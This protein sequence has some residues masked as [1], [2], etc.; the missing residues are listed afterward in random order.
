VNEE[1]SVRESDVA[2]FNTDAV[3]AVD[4]DL[5]QY[6]KKRA[7]TAPSRRFRICLHQSA[8]E[9]V[10]EMIVVHCRENYSRPHR[11]AAATSCLIIEGDLTVV[12]FDDDGRE[13][14]RIELGT[15][16][17]GKPFTLRLGPDIWHMPV[18]RS[19]QLV[20]YETLEG[21]FERER[22]NVWAPWS[23]NEDDAE[24]IARYLR[25]LGFA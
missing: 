17:S 22:V 16:D 5:I 3:L 19:E 4:D 12:L 11:H 1:G 20:F 6:L 15:R 8:E 18:C 9:A 2:L 7:R 25:S 10:Q 21:P 24:G 23:P 13:T 14:R